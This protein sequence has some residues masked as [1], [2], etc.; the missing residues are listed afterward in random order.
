LPRQCSSFA[1]IVT[2]GIAIAAIPVASELASHNDAR[3][4]A[5]INAASEEV[6]CRAARDFEV[7]A[8]GKILVLSADGKCIPMRQADLR[9][10]RKKADA[11]RTSRL[12]HRRSIGEKG[13]RKR[14]S[15]VA[16]VYTI[17]PFVGAPEDI[18]AG[19]QADRGSGSPN[20]R[21]R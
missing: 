5:G 4:A 13:H 2:G 10:Q 11:K 21:D 17:A 14:M 8:T 19:V 1:S 12:D 3:P 18:G 9:K 20:A 16:A 6:V 7:K 15:K